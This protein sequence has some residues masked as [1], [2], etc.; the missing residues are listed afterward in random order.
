MVKIL[1]T[2]KKPT[3]DSRD[4]KTKPV[5]W[6]WEGTTILAIPIKV[7]ECFVNLPT[8]LTWHCLKKLNSV[9]Q[10]FVAR[11]IEKSRPQ[12]WFWNGSLVQHKLEKLDWPFRNHVVYWFIVLVSKWVCVTVRSHSISFLIHGEFQVFTLQVFWHFCFHIIPDKQNIE[13]TSHLTNFDAPLFLEQK[14]KI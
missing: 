1:H 13:D 11:R 10:V 5:F 9:G 7:S 3:H 8:L 2:R 4:G 12:S 6:A 14:L